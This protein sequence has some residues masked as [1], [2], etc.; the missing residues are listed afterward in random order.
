MSPPNL[1]SIPRELR[2]EIYHLLLLPPQMIPSTAPKNRHS[3]HHFAKPPPNYIDKTIFLPAQF[4]IYLL[5]VCQQ[6]RAECTQTLIDI[7]NSSPKQSRLRKQCEGLVEPDPSSASSMYEAKK[8]LE[9]DMWPQITMDVLQH[10]HA[11][12]GG[13]HVPERTSLSPTFLSLLPIMQHVRQ[14]QFAI[15]PGWAWWNGPPKKRADPVPSLRSLRFHRVSG[16]PD[17]TYETTRPALVETS[18]PD[19]LATALEKVL[20]RLPCVDD[21]SIDVLMHMYNY[22]NFDLPDKKWER[23]QGW[24]DKPV[25]KGTG[26]RWKR[27][28]RQMVAVNF[29]ASWWLIPFYKKTEVWEDGDGEVQEGGKKGRIVHVVEEMT[30]VG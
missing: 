29:S 1:L 21:V 3:S 18:Q 9:T 20:A 14:L 13:M 30:E 22:S 15:W 16:S 23:V 5:H 10:V 28:R 24:L 19:Q 7:A 27:V 2:D 6:I 25:E 11:S 17:Q 26:R 4:P 8:L 12:F